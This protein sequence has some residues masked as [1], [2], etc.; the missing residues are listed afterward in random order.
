MTQLLRFVVWTAALLVLGDAS[1]QYRIIGFVYDAAEE[2]YIGN[3][4]R[5]SGPEG[6]MT[7]LTDQDGRFEFHDVARGEYNLI[8]LTEYG[9]IDRKVNVRTS[10][11]MHLQRPRNIR[12]NEVTVKAVRSKPTAPVV[13]YDMDQPEIESR[14]LGQDVPFVLKW[15]PSAVTTSDAG[16]G[17]G[18]TGIRIRGSDPTRINVTINGVPLNDSESQGVFWVD[19]PD[20]MSSTESIQI[21]RGVGESTYGTGAFGATLN[22]NTNDTR[23]DPYGKVS[24]TVGSFGT[25]RGMIQF[26]TGLIGKNFTIDGR[27]STIQSDG[28]IDRASADLRSYYGSAAYIGSKTSVRFTTFGGKEVTYQAWNGVPAQYIDDPELRTYNS[29]GTEKPG[30]PYENEVDDYTQTHYQLHVHQSIFTQLDGSLTM[31]YT[32][33]KGFFEQYKNVDNFESYFADYLSQYGL[34]NSDAVR[35]RWLDNDFYGFMASLYFTDP[36]EKFDLTL[37]GGYNVYDGDHFGE[38]IWSASGEDTGGLPP[39]YSNNARKSAV[40]L[41]GKVDYR[42]ASSW[43]ARLDLQYRGV[44]YSFEGLDADGTLVPQDVSHNFFNPKFGVT[45]RKSQ[46]WS[47][48]YYLGVANRE[49]NRDDYVDSSPSSRPSPE[50]LID[51]ELKFQYAAEKISFEAVGYYM[52]YKDQLVLTGRIND[53]GEYTRVN[54]DNSYRLGLETYFGYRPVSR[55]DISGGATLSRNIVNEFDEYIDNWDDGSQLVI[56][57]KNTPLSFSPSA[58]LMGRVGYDVLAKEKHKATISLMSKYVS[59]QFVDN[60]GN[61]ASRIDPY[62]FTEIQFEYFFNWKSNKQLALNFLVRN[63]FDVKYETNAWNYRFKSDSYDPVPDDPNAVSEGNGFY[64]LRGYY[65]QSGI[66]FLVGLTLTI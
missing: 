65:P 57:H 51:N 29:A 7:T 62:S 17:I 63:I 47:L 52:A 5:L 32:K 36:S 64:H 55:L 53:V 11:E 1:A 30:E 39:Y 61:E 60:S 9:I 35:R 22:L 43:T 10:L 59:S 56:E 46:R 23:V 24:G 21:Q 18:Y 20:L 16:T 28:Y 42:I 25:Y 48:S 45:Y 14:N 33:G 66:N 31:F 44:D 49:P 2:P 26:G 15:T 34:E 12:M 27:L 19:L 41:F 58:I 6:K 54:V 4:V 8:V 38:V 3:E 40:N 37:S 50:R 13:H